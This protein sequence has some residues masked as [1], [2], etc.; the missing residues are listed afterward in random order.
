MSFIKIVNQIIKIVA[1][2]KNIIVFKMYIFRRYAIAHRSC[3]ISKDVAK[4]F[5]ECFPF[6]KKNSYTVEIMFELSIVFPPT[7]ILLKIRRLT[8]TFVFVSFIIK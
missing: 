7:E 1:Q 5:V 2:K 8:K 6:L 3:Y 4:D